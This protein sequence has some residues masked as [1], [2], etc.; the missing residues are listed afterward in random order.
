MATMRAPSAHLS[1]SCHAVLIGG[2]GRLPPS[3]YHTV[4]SRVSEPPSRAVCM[5]SRV[6]GCARASVCV[7][8]HSR[9]HT[10]VYASS[11]GSGCKHLDCMTSRYRRRHATITAARRRRV[12]DVTPT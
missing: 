8:L 3:L 1:H 11:S 10:Y 6:L 4:S 2:L 5:P 7:C 12:A 9:E